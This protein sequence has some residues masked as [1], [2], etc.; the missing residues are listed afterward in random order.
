VS[1]L[2]TTFLQ[3]FRAQMHEAGG[4]SHQTAMNEALRRASVRILRIL[5][6]SWALPA[7]LGLI[8]PRGPIG[9]ER[10]SDDLAYGVES[11]TA[12]DVLE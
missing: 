12:L 1:F 8:H 6:S 7:S 9:R 5:S 4:G 10:F 3:W 2:T 11:G